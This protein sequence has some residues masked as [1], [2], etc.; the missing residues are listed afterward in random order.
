MFQKDN[1]LPLYYQLMDI[2]VSKIEAGDLK[3]HDK[4]PSERELCETYN[5]SRTTVRQTMQELEKE[6]LIY[7]EHGKGTFVSPKVIDQS[8]VKFYSFTDE[9]KKIN[10]IPSSNVLAFETMSADSHLAKKMSIIE[11]DPIYKIT[12]LRYADEE[13]MMYEISYLP[14]RRFPHLQVE[15][16]EKVPMYDLFRERYN[17]MITKANERFKA[18]STDKIAAEMLNIGEGEPSLFIER[19]TYENE[20]IIEYTATFARGDKFTYSVELN[21]TK[22]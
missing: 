12:R 22:E 13:P 9:M 7:K 8:L 4:L 20:E 16:L 19:M 18:V 2:I 3:E 15:D 14:I 6:K 17:V 10:K 21:S 1:R 5:V 11:N